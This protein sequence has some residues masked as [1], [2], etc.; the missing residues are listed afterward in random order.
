MTDFQAPN[1]RPEKNAPFR[2]WAFWLCFGL[3]ILF[4]T[5]FFQFSLADHWA[6]P[7]EQRIN[8]GERA[9][10]FAVHL[11]PYYV[12]SEDFHLY[13]VRAKRILDRGWTDSPLA[14]RKDEQLSHTAPLQTALMMLAVST[15]GR[16]VPYSI[17]VVSVL[18][19]AWSI[20][21][22][23][24]S[25][26]LPHSVSPLTIPV[27]V[28][29]TVLFESFEGLFHPVGEFGQWPVHRGLRMATLAWTSPLLLS[30]VLASVSLIFSREQPLRRLLF[31]LIA[32]LILAL[33]DTWAFLLALSC[34]GIAILAIGT[35]AVLRR[36]TDERNANHAW[37]CGMGLALAALIS[38]GAQQATTGALAGDV[39]TRAGFGPAWK[40]SVASAEESRDFFRTVRAYSGLLILF[41]TVV[42]FGGT[43]CVSRSPLKIQIEP[44]LRKP[45]PDLLQL[46]ALAA[47]PISG[48]VL[49]VEALS[50][51]GMDEYHLFQ[52][53]WRLQFVLFF[54]AMVVFSEAIKY[55]LRRFIKIHALST[56]WEIALTALFLTSLLVYHN[57]RIYR[58]VSRTVASEFFLTK[59]EEHL[60][61]WLREREK[62]LGKY[63]LATA[64]H[65]LNYLCAYWS[66]ADLL[67][68]E[69]FPYHN[70]ATND[71]IENQMA[72]V[73]RVYGSTP[74]K[75]LDFNL[76]RH[77]WGQW[78]WAD[79]RLLSAR[80]GYIYYLM[81][82]GLLVA[83]NAAKPIKSSQLTRTSAYYADVRLQHSE[84]ETQGLF[85]QH[86]A[87][88]EAAQ[89]IAKRLSA[90]PTFE[91]VEKPDV[92]VVD[93][94]SRALGTPDL[95]SYTREFKHGDLEAWVLKPNSPQ[96]AAVPKSDSL[97]K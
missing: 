8:D 95:S 7:P 46:L 31:V 18:A 47:V 13:V 24:A 5:G 33:A 58:F 86:K 20:L 62:S 70:T 30:I 1:S 44:R 26:C 40:G 36:R 93:E 81:H 71:E 49:L 16:P 27:A 96:S 66:R 54:C 22:V 97:M 57:V 72:H 17:F 94:V 48:F 39:L 89:R 11:N 45:E 50:H 79:S 74:E 59:D 25:R 85:K 68:P 63:S 3:I 52:F 64:S 32:I 84:A 6:F 69:G 43:I 88:K 53:V 4:A 19:V 37:V 12:F 92:I 51:M 15:D 65:E 78:S 56:K 87:G 55:G 76:H 91:Q 42:F 35:I 75:W 9:T 73:L 41:G 82:R 38:L 29:L 67:L 34:V 23:V 60:R 14:S 2:R 80:H 90:L 77:V 10:F 21:Y 83:G 61:D 28:L